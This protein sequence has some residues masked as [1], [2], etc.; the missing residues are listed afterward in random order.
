MK[1]K[2]LADEF[3]CC[4]CL[5]RTGKVP[6]WCTYTNPELLDKDNFKQPL[7]CDTCDKSL[8]NY[9]RNGRVHD[10]LSMIAWAARRAREFEHDRMTSKITELAYKNSQAVRNLNRLIE[11]KEIL[12]AAKQPVRSKGTTSY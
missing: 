1:E 9:K 12:D 4:V 3:K 6:N 8:T 2:P 5:E 11:S 7:L 10:N